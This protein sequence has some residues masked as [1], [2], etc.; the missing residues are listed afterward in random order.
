MNSYTGNGAYCYANSTSMLLK[1]AGADVSPSRLEVLTGV[2]LGG[3]WLEEDKILYFGNW[4]CAPY[5]G[6]GEALRLLGFT[7][8]EKVR[9]RAADPAAVL[10][11]LRADLQHGPVVLGPLDMGYL[12]YNPN[13]QW[14]FGSDHYVLA[15]DM[16]DEYLYL[17]DPAGFPHVALTLAQLA[18]AWRT[19]CFSYRPQAY[20]CW[21][22]PV[23]VQ[24]PGEEE[25][26]AGALAY[27]KSTYEDARAYA[28]Q[29]GVKEGRDAILALADVIA[30]GELT[31][32]LRGHLSYFL[33]QLGAKRALDYAEFFQAR[34]PELA[35]LK[36][37]QAR[38]F[39]RA[40]TQLVADR[41]PELTATVREL[42]EVEA[43]FREAL[44][45]A[46]AVQAQG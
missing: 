10:A 9:D 42:A 5:T 40:H 29:H 25:V 21:L 39:G 24:T 41:L 33:F 7:V 26:Y 32:E 14:L 43:E 35:V 13:W 15:Y 27:F 8:T 16:D 38:L 20:Q 23:R 19:D 30:A 6:I 12:N 34:N 36:N 4:D 31:P 11:E 3:L 17:H 37:A 18:E 45:A 22:N 28:Q 2:G 1:S 46:C 44:F